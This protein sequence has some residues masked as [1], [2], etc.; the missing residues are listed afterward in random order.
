MH[1]LTCP[2]SNGKTSCSCASRSTCFRFFQRRRVA[3]ILGN[4]PQ[5]HA[6]ASG[7]RTPRRG[8]AC[9]AL[10]SSLEV[11]Q[12]MEVS[13]VRKP[14]HFVHFPIHVLLS[15]HIERCRSSPLEKLSP[16]SFSNDHTASPPG[17]HY[18]RPVMD[19]VTLGFTRPS[20]RAPDCCLV[21]PKP[22]NELAT[23][24]QHARRGIPHEILRSYLNDS[25]SLL[26]LNHLATKQGTARPIAVAK[27][28]PGLVTTFTL[29]VTLL[30]GPTSTPMLHV[31]DFR[32][33]I[34]S[35]C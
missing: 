8:F 33:G 6:S 25:P 22:R 19:T 15:L 1:L 20:F 9:G 31:L 29:M 16:K 11:L 35:T 13:V 34:V 2:S 27:D 14:P 26:P 3:G 32:P 24:L 30:G 28:L 23:A 5:R 21:P 18:L 10:V 17:E 7:H 4:A 12:S